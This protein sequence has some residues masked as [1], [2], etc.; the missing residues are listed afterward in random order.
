MAHQVLA[1]ANRGDLAASWQEAFERLTGELAGQYETQL[2]QLD[3]A[4][5]IRLRTVADRIHERFVKPLAL[6]RLCALIEPAMEEAS[7]EGKKRA[8]AALQREIKPF[9]ATPTGVGLDVP[10]WLRRMEEEVRKVHGSQSSLAMLA[11]KLLRVPRLD[12]SL[13]EIRQQLENWEQPFD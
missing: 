2:N 5:G 11:E 3:Q 8:F 9:V 6:D 1:D 10:E 7:Q 12:V 13:P 4:H